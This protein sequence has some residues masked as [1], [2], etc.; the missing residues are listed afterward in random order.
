[1]HA[2]SLPPPRESSNEWGLPVVL[3]LL[4][5]LLVAAIFI[6]AWVWSPP[7]N[8]EAA[9]GDPA[10]EASLQVSSAEAAAARQAL[11]ASENLPDLPEPVEE[12]PPE[13]V[14][15]DTVP[16]P[17]PI[18][19]PRPQDAPTPQQHNAQERIAQPDNVDQERVSALAISQEK[20]KQ[21]QE[22]KRRQEQIDLT[23][24]KRVEEAEQKLRL[25]KQQEEA[26]RQKKL[27]DEQRR[28]TDSA[29]QE[30]QQKIAE[31]RRKREQA[32]REA[33]LA[34]QRL[35]QVA[36]ARARAQGASSSNTAA[37]GPASPSPGQGGTSNDD[38]AK[39]AAAIQQAVLNQWVRPDSIP[40]GQRCRLTIRQVPGGSVIR[41]EFAPSC[42]YDEAGRRSVEAAILR[43][44][45][46]PYR[47]FEN[48]FQPSLNFNFEPQ[49]R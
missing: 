16:P 9:A 34:E 18:P 45:P 2:D 10:V 30:R 12:V 49:D 1:M 44:Q 21:E 8:T 24:R 23:E 42:P 20:A 17:Q 5:H 11:R 43:A 33:K 31:I 28:A 3:A 38:T 19:E 35:R 32:E 13:P 14:P 36:D 41:V 25:A 7:R 39:Y 29:E 4:V 40:R 26:D 22:A 15:E 48:V 37:S 46:L 27:A 47:G 6:I